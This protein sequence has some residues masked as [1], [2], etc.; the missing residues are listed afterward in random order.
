ML[1][2]VPS[3]SPQFGS[4]P[5]FVPAKSYTF[6]LKNKHRS[7]IIYAPAADTAFIMAKTARNRNVKNTTATVPK[8]LSLNRRKEAINET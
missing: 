7:A 1:W 4:V 5:L 8:I 2:Q 6:A 3:Q